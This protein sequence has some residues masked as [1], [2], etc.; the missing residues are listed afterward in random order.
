MPIII[1]GVPLEFFGDFDDLQDI[2][3][4]VVASTQHPHAVLQNPTRGIKNEE[5]EKPWFEPQFKLKFRTRLLLKGQQD[6]TA[7]L[8]FEP[9]QRRDKRWGEDA[10][11]R[12]LHD[13]VHDGTE[14]FEISPVEIGLAPKPIIT[15][16]LR[17]SAFVFC[18]FCFRVHAGNPERLKNW[19]L[20]LK[21]ES[22][23]V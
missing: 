1:F 20:L 8:R 11:L 18:V 10:F 9:Q 23:K 15:V 19:F 17:L 2:R 21:F 22:L 12:R 4:T 13:R 5:M 3:N 6:L 16:I 14:S 7:A